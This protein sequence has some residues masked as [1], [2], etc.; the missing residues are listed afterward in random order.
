M[1][2]NANVVGYFWKINW[3]HNQQLQNASS[4]FVYYPSQD[5]KNGSSPDLILLGLETTALGVM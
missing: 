4:P 3:L 5:P 1:L 2:L